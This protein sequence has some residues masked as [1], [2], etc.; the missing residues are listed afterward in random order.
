[1]AVLPAASAHLSKAVELAGEHQGLG[2]NVKVLATV[3]VKSLSG[4]DWF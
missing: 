1:M 4:R 3:I 2:A